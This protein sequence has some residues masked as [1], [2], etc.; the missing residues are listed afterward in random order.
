MKRLCM[1]DFGV[2]TYNRRLCG[3]KQRLL[4]FGGLLQV[5]ALTEF[6]QLSV[7]ASF[8]VCNAVLLACWVWDQLSRRVLS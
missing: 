8:S 1:F 2:S 7:C 6:E 4:Q 5:C 3:W